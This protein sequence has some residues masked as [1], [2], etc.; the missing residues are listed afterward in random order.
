MQGSWAILGVIVSAPLLLIV[1]GCPPGTGLASDP[2][3]PLATT[4]AGAIAAQ[5]DNNGSGTN[6]GAGGSAGD[7]SGDT[8]EVPIIGPAENPFIISETTLPEE[9]CGGPTVSPTAPVITEPTIIVTGM[10][11]GGTQAMMTVKCRATDPDGVIVR[12]EADLSPFGGD[13]HQALGQ[14][15]PNVPLYEWYFVTEGGL[16]VQQVIVL[17]VTDDVGETTTAELP[18][19]VEPAAWGAE[20][21][22]IAFASGPSYLVV[23]VPV[24]AEFDCCVV[25]PNAVVTSVSVDLGGLG[26]PPV[27]LEY[28]GDSLWSVQV[29]INAASVGTHTI[30]Y[31]ALTTGTAVLSQT[32]EVTVR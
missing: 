23:G 22:Y 1:G 25:D 16:G 13:A 20:P 24:K 30:T 7:G 8:S 18:I 21:P 32:A 11:G 29:W 10:T 27:P 14:M 28:M 19:L 9:F 26:L 4:L 31:R 5:G 17:R 6:A 3:N 12:V 15:D 2:N